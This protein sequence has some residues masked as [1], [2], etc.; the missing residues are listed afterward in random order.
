MSLAASIESDV[1]RAMLEKNQLVVAVLRL[2][3]A[4][5]K[6]EMITLKK[7]ELADEEV[8]VVLRREVKK[9]KDAIE[10]YAK[11]GRPELAEAEK[12]EIEVIDK[13]LPAQMAEDEVRKV[14]G[15]VVA[16]RGSGG[17]LQFGAVMGAVMAK[18]KG[19]ADGNLVSRLVKEQLTTNN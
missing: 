12:R 14:V 13:Y 19:R 8:L 9:R 18:L 11:G 16:G 10:Q 7:Q 6:N 17:S 1:K 2:L 15:E 5:L 4:A 3:K